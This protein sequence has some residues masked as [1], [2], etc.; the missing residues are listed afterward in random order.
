MI[1]EVY[2]YVPPERIDILESKRICFSTKEQLNDNYEFQFKIKACREDVDEQQFLIE[3]ILKSHDLKNELALLDSMKF[4]AEHNLGRSIDLK[5]FLFLLLNINQNGSDFIKGLVK[6]L[7]K[8][9]IG[10]F[11]KR[12]CVLCLSNNPSNN[13]MW[14]YYAKS[15]TGFMI[16]FN[17]EHPFFNK[18]K[19]D[20]DVV[21]SLR[22]V[23]YM[24]EIPI[25]Y[26]KDAI[27]NKAEIETSIFYNKHTDHLAEQECRFLDIVENAA[28]VTKD[29]YHLFDLP[30]G[31]I[32]SITFGHNM[33]S[34]DEMNIKNII[35]ND[36]FFDGVS[37]YKASPN[38]DSRIIERHK[39]KLVI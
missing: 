12:L 27:D 15:Y 8:E 35:T 9:A 29:G 30:K 32:T 26:L 17:S 37:L 24:D 23:E 2:K 28:S 38:D 36:H 25:L 19:N 1:N 31:L 39:L 11:Q 4:I 16:G 7:E 22:N 18:K 5:E 13:L 3:Q 34:N 33:S 20:F 14:G 21:R 6:I 10:A